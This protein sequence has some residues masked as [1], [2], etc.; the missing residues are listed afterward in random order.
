MVFLNNISTITL[1][2]Y[3]PTLLSGCKLAYRRP[4]ARLPQVRS[5]CLRVAASA[6]AGGGQA[7]PGMNDDIRY[8]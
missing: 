7:C 5:T 2:A 8:P 6:K 4:W 3:V 1:S